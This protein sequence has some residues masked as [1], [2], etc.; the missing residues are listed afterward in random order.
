MI[1]CVC[2]CVCEHVR[3]LLCGQLVKALSIERLQVQ[4]PPVT[5][6]KFRRSSSSTWQPYPGTSKLVNWGPGFRA[7]M[8]KTYSTEIQVG[9]GRT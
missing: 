4:V 8:D 5:L 9:L 3:V 7:E 1:G 6:E 2:V